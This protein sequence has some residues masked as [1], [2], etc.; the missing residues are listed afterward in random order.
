MWGLPDS[1]VYGTYKRAKG[2]GK[3]RRKSNKHGWAYNTLA[4]A[5]REIEKAERAKQK[6]R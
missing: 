4:E 2:I 5:I 6:A 3:P 1:A